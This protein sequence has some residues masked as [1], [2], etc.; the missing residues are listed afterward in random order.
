MKYI[1]LFKIYYKEP[2][3]W[4]A[5]RNARYAS[6]F[7]KTFA[8]PI[9]EYNHKKS[10]QAFATF[11]LELT[12]LLMDIQSAKEELENTISTS[13]NILIDYLKNLFLIEEIKASNDI[14]GVFSS[15]HEIKD[16]LNGYLKNS[17]KR[18]NSIISKYFSVLHP[19]EVLFNITTCEDVRTLYDEFILSEISLENQLDGKLF[20]ADQVNITTKTDRIIHQG[21]YPEEKIIEYMNEALSVLNTEDMPLA[22]RVS[23]FHYFF[24]Y[25]HPF[26]DGN[27]RTSRFISTAYLSHD[28]HPLIA[29]RLS[30]VIKNNQKKYYEAFSHTNSE[31]NGG[32]LT[33]FIFE[34]LQI[35]QQ[36][37]QNT[38]LL[39]ERRIERLNRNK[40]RLQKFFNEQH[41]TDKVTQKIYY[42]LMQAST[43]SLSSGVTREILISNVQKS[44]RTIDSR[45][46][47]IPDAHIIITKEGR[48]KHFKLNMTI[49]PTQVKE[50]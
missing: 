41:I 45:L 1:P 48:T 18:F 46:K 10:Y 20:R 4:E 26:Y 17:P 39:L 14:E 13:A 38:R 2:Q 42:I 5:K 44:A 28:F 50:R 31:I 25:I 22:I 23:L 19:S 33:Y 3:N 7:T 30:T 24:G 40:L 21:S 43:F 29:L 16:S 34:F 37:I 36:T 32:D 6:E 15:R 8:I 35:I 11:P 9:K 27:G 47:E 49:L 12:N